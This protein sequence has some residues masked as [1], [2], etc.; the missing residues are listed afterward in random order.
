MSERNKEMVRRFYEEVLG[1]Q[2][3]GL[4]EEIMSDDFVDHDPAPGTAPDKKGAIEGFRMM[5]QAFPDMSAEINDMVVEGDRVAAN[6]TFRGTNE[7]EF[8][9]MPATGK[10]IEAGAIDIVR[11]DDEGMAVEHWGIFDAMGMLQQMG[12]VPGQG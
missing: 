11:L 12:V 8:A 9:G 10:A 1:K 5:F 6:I 3:L 7:G 2:D 4:A